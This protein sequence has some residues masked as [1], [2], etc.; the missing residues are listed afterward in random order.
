MNPTKKIPEETLVTKAIEEQL[1]EMQLKQIEVSEET[2]VIEIVEEEKVD[3][4]PN[5][6]ESMPT[7]K[8]M[9]LN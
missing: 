9:M 3:E 1:E 5:G 2:G 8:K 6:S 7:F 4:T